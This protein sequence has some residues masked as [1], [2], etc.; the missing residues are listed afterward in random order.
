MKS[1]IFCFI[2]F[3][4]LSKRLALNQLF[5]LFYKFLRKLYLSSIGF[6]LFCSQD[7]IIGVNIGFIDSAEDFSY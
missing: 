4:N 5:K 2:S 6:V 7:N 1:V 3:Q